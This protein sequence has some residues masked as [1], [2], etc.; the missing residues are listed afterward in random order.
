MLFGLQGATATFQR[1]ID[2][3][4]MGTGDFSAAY[5]DDLV[6]FSEL[7]DLHVIHLVVSE[8]LFERQGS[9]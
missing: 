2:Q 9:L 7:W 4:L 8:K 6:V 5:L 3:L 1:L